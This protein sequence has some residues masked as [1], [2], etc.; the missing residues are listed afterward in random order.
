MVLKSKGIILAE[1]DRK[2]L[3]NAVAKRSVPLS[4]KVRALLKIKMGS[5][6]WLLKIRVELDCVVTVDQLT[7]QAKFTTMFVIVDR[8]LGYENCYFDLVQFF[9]FA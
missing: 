9:Y 6:I 3:V 5:V 8:I 1:S 2:A 7:A 4:L